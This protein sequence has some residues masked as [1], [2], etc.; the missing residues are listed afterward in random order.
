MMPIA[1]DDGHNPCISSFAPDF[2][3]ILIWCAYHSQL[4]TFYGE[5]SL[6]ITFQYLDNNQIFK[7]T[8]KTIEFKYFKM[9]NNS[10]FSFTSLLFHNFSYY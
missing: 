3:V 5:S 6:E 7:S 8:F 10:F 1:S 4:K 2:T 9:E